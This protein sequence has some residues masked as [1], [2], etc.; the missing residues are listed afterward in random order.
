M[1]CIG[2][3]KG[4]LLAAVEPVS[5]ALFSIIWM[6]VHF[7]WMDALGFAFIISTIYLLSADK[8]R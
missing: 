8:K 7:V 2:P 4:S 5:A 6:K 3:K 1:R